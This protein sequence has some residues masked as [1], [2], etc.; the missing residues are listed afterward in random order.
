MNEG[1]KQFQRAQLNTKLLITSSTKIWLVLNE[2]KEQ[3]LN[4]NNLD[5]GSY[6]IIPEYQSR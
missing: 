6:T 4:Q 3:L 2:K 5:M 1:Y